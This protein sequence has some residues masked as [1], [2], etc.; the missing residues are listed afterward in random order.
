M[1]KTSTGKVFEM[2]ARPALELNGYRVAFQKIVGLGVGGGAHRE[3]IIVTKPDGEEL[4][5]SMKWQQVSGTA[6]QKVPYEVIK[7]IHAVKNSASRFPYAYLVI[8]GDGWTPS[9]LKFYLQHGLRDYI[10]DYDL[11]RL[12]SLNDFI[13]RANKKKL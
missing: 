5:V 7:L 12:V 2:T 11:V 4:L 13:A 6:E 10:R 1:A 9:L 8:G 3:D